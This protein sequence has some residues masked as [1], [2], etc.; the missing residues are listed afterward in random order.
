MKKIVSFIFSVVI[1]SASAIA[2]TS[3]TKTQKGHTNQNK[4]RQLKEM[5]TTPN[6]QHTASGAP[7]KDYS[8]QKVDYEMSI[9]LDDDNQ[10]ITG[11]ETITYHNNSDDTLKYLW[12]QLDQNVRARIQ[13]LQTLLRVVKFQKN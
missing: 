12:V 11:N 6:S 7:G 5:L 9:V 3:S 10:K 4:F 13:K 2:Q 1:I 8:Q